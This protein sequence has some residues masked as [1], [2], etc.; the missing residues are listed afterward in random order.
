MMAA[1]D[2]RS[3]GMIV[4]NHI[5]QSLQDF[6]KTCDVVSPFC[7]GPGFSLAMVWMAVRTSRAVNGLPT[8]LLRDRKR[9]YKGKPF[10]CQR[11]TVSGFTI[12]S[13]LD[14]HAEHFGDDQL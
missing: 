13:G 7:G 5:L 11:T 10:R 2:E 6:L 3:K 14:H 1:R 12:R 9:Q 8:S 4:N